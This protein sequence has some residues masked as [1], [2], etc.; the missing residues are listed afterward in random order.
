LRHAAR[1]L[2]PRA[3]GKPPIGGSAEIASGPIPAGAGETGSNHSRVLPA[4]AYPRGRGGNLQRKILR[5][6][7]LG[8]SPRARGKRKPV[9][10]R[11]SMSRPIPAGAGETTTPRTC[12]SWRRAYPRGR[13]GNITVRAYGFMDGG[14]SPQARG[15]LNN[16]IP[17]ASTRGPIPAGAGETR[18]ARGRRQDY[19][20][21]PRGRGGNHELLT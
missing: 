17:G 4:M 13:G 3:R 9:K 11:S 16:G 5:F 6:G 19:R 1:G 2:S 18:S 20:A 21:Y 12:S 7:Q 10:A 8:L 15:K 14:L